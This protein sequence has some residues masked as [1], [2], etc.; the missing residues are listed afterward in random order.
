MIKIDLR[1]R[2]TEFPQ[3]LDELTPQQYVY[4]IHLAS[5][6]AGGLIDLEFWRC[7]WFS[8]LAGLGESNY[9]MLKPEFIAEAEALLHPVTDPFL[10]TSGKR[11]APTF[12]TCRNLLPE[13]QG[14]KGPS[15]WLNEV[16]FGKFVECATL[17]EQAA[18]SPDADEIYHGIA[19]ALYSIAEGDTVPPV[20]AW[21]APVLFGSVLST[22]QS[23]PIEINGKSIDFSIIFKSSG[24]RRPDD[25]T[26]WAGIS[27]EV[28]AAGLFGTVKE[29]E[30]V[31]FWSVL[32]YLYKCKFEYLHDKP[33]N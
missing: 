13:Y 27:F 19:R 29:L 25:R 23:G 24:P 21:H 33:K 15:D 31:P 11:I 12:R 22:I 7:R 4:Y 17:Y 6:L 26:G 2:A 18:V 5:C 30:E 20:L 3:M 10:S 32:M 1:G 9:T 28:A 14:Y 8:F 16:S